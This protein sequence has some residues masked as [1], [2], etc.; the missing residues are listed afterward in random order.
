[1]PE[2]LG[3]HS[4]KFL[5]LILDV[6]KMPSYVTA[7]GSNSVLDQLT[8]LRGQRIYQSGGVPDSADSATEQSYLL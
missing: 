1:M 7:S 5:E 8:H 3:K 4:C 2:C 6:P